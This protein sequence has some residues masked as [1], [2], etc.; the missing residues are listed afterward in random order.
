MKLFF[1]LVVATFLMPGCEIRKRE[2][3]LDQKEAAL[4]QKEQQ[5]LLREKSIQVKEE[6]LLSR[7]KSLDST[8]KMRIADTLAA[9]YPALPGSYSVTMSCTET[10]C[11]GSAVGDTKTEQWE[12]TIENNTVFA[13]AFSD[14]KLVRIYSGTYVN[15]LLE[16]YAQQ[17]QTT[18]AQTGEI[19]VRIQA[20][21]ENQFEGQREIRKD[22]CR[23]LYK[24]ALT[25]Q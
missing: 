4:N 16:L 15:N 18:T 12:L 5:L 20:T 21:K 19:I 9:L 10:T 6:E 24:L 23:I 8:T 25:K 1:L 14:G 7:E 22:R 13:K 2:M 3:L 17:D 11:A